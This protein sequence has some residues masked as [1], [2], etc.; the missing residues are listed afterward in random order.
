MKKKR[1]KSRHPPDGYVMLPGVTHPQGRPQA[2][3][4]AMKAMVRGM[5]EIND[6]LTVA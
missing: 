3:A 6:N 4:D 5:I 2:F 1:K